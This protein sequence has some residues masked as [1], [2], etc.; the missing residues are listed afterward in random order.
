MA[1]ISRPKRCTQCQCNAQ[2]NKINNAFANAFSSMGS[3]GLQHK[4]PPPSTTKENFV[5][6]SPSDDAAIVDD[7]PAVMPNETTVDMNT[8][9]INKHIEEAPHEAMDADNIEAFHGEEKH[10]ERFREIM[11]NVVAPSSKNGW[12]GTNIRINGDNKLF[13]GANQYDRFMKCFHKVRLFFILQHVG[14]YL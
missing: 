9:A 3:N 11:M 1:P 5:A 10:G 12:N 2:C 13:P 8:A 14:S 6:N 7:T 4:N